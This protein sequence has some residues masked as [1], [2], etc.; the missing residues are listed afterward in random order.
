MASPS[1]FIQALTSTLKK[2]PVAFPS[3]DAILIQSESE[4]QSERFFFRNF[5]ECRLPAN[6]YDSEGRRQINTVIPGSG[7][8][9]PQHMRM[10]GQSASGCAF[11]V[12]DEKLFFLYDRVERWLSVPDQVAFVAVHLDAEHL[13][14]LAWETVDVRLTPSE[15]VLLS[16]LLSGLDLQAA[17]SA[18]DAS[19]DTKR[20]QIRVVLEKFGAKTQTAL[21]RTLSLEITS[22]VLDEIL[23]AQQHSPETVLL[24]KQFG[25]NVVVSRLTIGDNTEIPVWEF[26]ARRGRPV[27]FFHSM[28][29]PILLPEELVDVL[30]AHDLRWLIV[31]RHFL[32]HTHA[33][34]PQMSLIR[35]SRA[36][37]ETVTYLTDEPVLCVAES[38]GVTWALHFARHHPDLVSRLVMCGAPQSLYGTP[39]SQTIFAELSLRLR[40]DPRVLVGLTQVYNALCR[41]PTFAQKGLGHLFRKSPADIACLETLFERAYLGDWVQLIANHATLTSMDEMTTLQRDWISDLR[42]IQCPLSFVHGAEDPISPIEDVVEIAENVPEAAFVKIENAG[43]LVLSTHFRSLI[44]QLTGQTIDLTESPPATG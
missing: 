18:V 32:E 38:A 15:Y 23:P 2:T 16:H 27:L 14:A 13:A 3:E 36:L 7:T 41:V 19:Y 24:K 11:V 44:G 29:S 34:D 21:L 33:A 1:Q 12:V 25:R 28:L 31:P 8:E 22:A 30:K 17:A 37:A 39:H 20:K 4:G 5:S 42:Q 26:G 43:H 35:F 40:R 9:F 10:T 6:L